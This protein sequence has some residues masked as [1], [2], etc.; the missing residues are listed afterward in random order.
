MKTA[1]MCVSYKKCFWKMESFTQTLV[2]ESASFVGEMLVSCLIPPNAF[3]IFISVSKLNHCS[4]TNIFSKLLIFWLIDSTG[5]GDNEQLSDDEHADQEEDD[6][7]AEWRKQR[8]ERE[9][10]LK[11]QQEV[12]IVHY[13]PRDHS[14]ELYLF[15]CLCTMYY[16][17]KRKGMIITKKMMKFWKIVS[18]YNLGSLFSS[19]VA[20]AHWT[21]PLRKIN[22]SNFLR[23]IHFHLM[24]RNPM[25]FL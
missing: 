11:E 17:S 14:C 25:C 5:M 18:F 4:G 10:F 24:G 15:S 9:M 19:N 1:E 20:Q 2:E 16:R 23:Q 12:S 7:D 3:A 22:L 13:K 8:H 21:C 6:D